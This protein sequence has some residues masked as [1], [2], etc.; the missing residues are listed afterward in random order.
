MHQTGIAGHPNFSRTSQ[1]NLTTGLGACV[2]YFKA[3]LRD[4]QKGKWHAKLDPGKS[5]AYIIIDSICS[6]LFFP[7]GTRN[8]QQNSNAGTGAPFMGFD[9]GELGVRVWSS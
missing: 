3:P 7:A 1:L 4:G 6:Q 8:V 9:F 2:G 5:K